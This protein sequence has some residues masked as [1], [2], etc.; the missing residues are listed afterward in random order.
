M[1]RRLAALAAACGVLLAGPAFAGPAGP[2]ALGH[3]DLA[4]SIP[5]IGEVVAETPTELRLVFTERF[6][7]AFSSL[8]LLDPSGATILDDAGAPDPQDPYLLV[9]PLPELPAGD[10]IYTV[11]WQA[12]SSADGH[13]T[14]GTYTFGVGDVAPPPGGV[15]VGGGGSLHAGHGAG[16][17]ILETESRALSY[18]GL[19]LAVGLPVIGWLVLRRPIPARVLA[20]VLGLSAFGS[21]GLLLVSAT[22]AGVDPLA[23]ATTGRSGLLFTARTAIAILG[24]LAVWLAGRAPRPRLA[25]GLAAAFGFVGLV[26]VALVGHASAFASPAPTVAIVL[27]LAAAGVW[28]SGLT[29]LAWRAVTRDGGAPPI[30]ELV[31]RFTGLALVAVALIAITGIYSDWVQ[32]RDLLG[33]GTPY[34]LALLV[35]VVIVAGALAFGFLNFLDGGHDR[36]FLGGFR[37]RILVEASLAVVVVLA[38]GNLTSGSPPATARAIELERAISSAA[39]LG[40]GTALVLE[41]GRPGPTRFTATIE[42]AG[43]YADAVLSLE[44]LDV[45]GEPTRFPLR[46]VEADGPA[47]HVVDGTLIQAGTRWSASILA[48]DAAGVEI[49]RARY[50]FEMGPDGLVAGR[51]TPAIDPSLVVVAILLLGGLLVTVFAVA[52]GGLPRADLRTARLASVAGS[53]AGAGLAVV[54]L[55]AGEL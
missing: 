26:A 19:L 32:T 35:K 27:H 10:G 39:A 54:I 34:G 36:A 44:R 42:T 8:D 38:T 20:G 12:L 22:T 50:Q 28:V 37:A 5:G 18:L 41:P 4:A 9:A 16:L 48:L 47:R 45:A 52:G 15:D 46:R 2:V 29:A 11:R 31:P 6:E 55:V 51:A 17:A 53:L 3:A 13:T 14:S 21:V 40:D 24:A 25:G 23:Y 7:P 49:A 43:E 30:G 33:F 1:A